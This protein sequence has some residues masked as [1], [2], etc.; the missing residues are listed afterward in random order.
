MLSTY[1]STFIWIAFSFGIFTFIGLD[2][3]LSQRRSHPPSFTQTLLTYGFWSLLT[4]IF[5]GGL[6]YFY[7][8]KQAID[9]VTGYF[10]EE[11]LS[12]DN[13]FVF[14]VIFQHFKIPVA[15]QHRV[16]S[17][18]IFGALLMRAGF[19]LLGA[20]LLKQFAFIFYILG[21]FLLVTAWRLIRHHEDSESSVVPEK[22]LQW[23]RRMLPWPVTTHLVEGKFWTHID[24]RRYATPLVL[25]LV[26]VECSDLL[27]ALD[28]VPAIFAITTD[29]FVI[30]TSNVFAILSLRSLY[31]LLANMLQYFRFLKV[32]LGVILAFVGGKMLL[33]EVVEISALASLATVLGILSVTMFASWLRPKKN[34]T[35]A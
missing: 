23:L 30:Y 31:F 10:I 9:F 18:G 16:L 22:P 34:P 27:F 17:W 21:A 35:K 20:A 7:S 15:Y 33:H 25:A 3:L 26:L 4:A 32:G 14:L 5:A 2:L 19:I 24:N 28:S 11:A 8:A 12:V 1:N 6:A 13:L 29:A